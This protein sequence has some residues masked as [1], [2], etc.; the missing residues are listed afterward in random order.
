MRKM[1]FVK[2]AFLANAI[3]IV[4]VAANVLRFQ[5]GAEDAFWRTLMSPF[6]GTVWTPQFS[7]SAFAKIEVG[8]AASEVVGL[9]GKPLRRD[10]GTMG[11]F[12]IYTWHDSDTADFDQRWVVFDVAERVS[13]IRKS[14][15]ID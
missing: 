5:Y 2:A 14:F 12:W 15:F 3:F 10:C 4:A 13:E 11:C 7:E 6:E 9:V 1:K 8:M